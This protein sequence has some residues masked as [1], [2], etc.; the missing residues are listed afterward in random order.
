MYL[1]I[2]LCHF[3]AIDSL[4][5]RITRIFYVIENYSNS[6]SGRDWYF[7]ILLIAYRKVNFVL[8]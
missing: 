8:K 5:L 2:L 4:L 3:N 6:Y 7:L 1:E